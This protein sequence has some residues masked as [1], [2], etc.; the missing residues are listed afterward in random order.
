MFHKSSFLF[1]FWQVRNQDFLRE[2]RVEGCPLFRF[3]LT[4]ILFEF[5]ALHFKNAGIPQWIVRLASFGTN[6]KTVYDLYV[7]TFVM[8]VL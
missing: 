2:G 8:K 1:D 6:G 5:K 3:G 7:G 4:S